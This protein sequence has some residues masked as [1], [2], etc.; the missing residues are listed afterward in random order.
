MRIAFDCSIIYHFLPLN[1]IKSIFHGPVKRKWTKKGDN[2]GG[3][4]YLEATTK[5]PREE[6]EAVNEESA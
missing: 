4:V 5:V 6:I 1:T 3:M 2:R